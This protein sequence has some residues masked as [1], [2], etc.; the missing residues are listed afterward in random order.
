MIEVVERYKTED[1]SLFEDL[2]EAELHQRH[3]QFERDIKE[4]VDE[5]WFS[6]MDEKAIVS[7]LNTFI[8]RF[9]LRGVD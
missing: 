6:D 8:K 5:E 1:G 3:L 7:L 2:Q 9:N 4:F